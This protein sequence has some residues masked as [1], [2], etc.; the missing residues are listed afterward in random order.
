MYLNRHV[1]ELVSN[2][3]SMVMNPVGQSD[4]QIPGMKIN[5]YFLYNSV[6]YFHYLRL[7]HEKLDR[8]RKKNN[9]NMAMMVIK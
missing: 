7:I 2:G 1:T 5:T 4:Q 8:I 9:V 3:I 6:N